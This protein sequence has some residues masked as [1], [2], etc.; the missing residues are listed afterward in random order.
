[1]LLVLLVDPVTAL[2][3]DQAVR[4]QRPS[5]DVSN[6]VMWQVGGKLAGTLMA[7]LFLVPMAEL[8][9]ALTRWLV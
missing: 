7:Q 1:V 2:V 6:V 5:G 4:G 3:T 8:L 9:A